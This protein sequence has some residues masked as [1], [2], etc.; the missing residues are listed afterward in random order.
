M[1]KLIIICLSI[2]INVISAK[3]LS[4]IQSAFLDIGF[5]ARAMGMG[6]AYTAEANKAYASSWNP[7]GLNWQNKKLSMAFSTVKLWKII[8]YKQL[9]YGYNSHKGFS[10]GQMLI[11]SGDEI[12]SE[13]TIITNFAIQGDKI[14]GLNLLQF[15]SNISLGISGKYFSSTYGNNSSGSYVDEMGEH[16][17]SGSASGYGF[18]LGLNVKLTE[19]D[20]LG[21]L[22]RN[23]IN[24]IAWNSKNEVHTARGEYEEDLPR[25]FIVGYTKY[26]RG[27]TAA[28]DWNVSLYDNV[29]DVISTGIEAPFLPSLIGNYLKLRA[30]YSREIFTSNAEIY[31]LGAGLKLPFMKDKFMSID[32]AYQIQ[33]IWKKHNNFRISFCLEL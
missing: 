13:T 32:L 10:F 19:Q 22:Y 4:N 18:D 30:G 5:G 7:A 12:M 11:S 29:E 3:D 31:S 21:I 1:K 6:G 15:A 27:V 28:L 26:I 14:P 16:Q 9:A 20:K 33:T 8:N 17:V 25:E 2:A 23:G 24:N